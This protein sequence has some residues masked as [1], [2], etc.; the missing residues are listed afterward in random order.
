MKDPGKNIKRLRI[1]LLIPSVTFHNI[2][3]HLA[4][5]LLDWHSILFPYPICCVV[6]KSVCGGRRKTVAVKNLNCCMFLV[7]MRES[8]YSSAPLKM[9]P[10]SGYPVY[11]MSYC[12]AIFK[13]FIVLLSLSLHSPKK[14]FAALMSCHRVCRLLCSCAC[15]VLKTYFFWI[16]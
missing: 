16:L 3:I 14:V 2:M 15:R 11:Q 6:Y 4:N 10:R 9:N 8:V 1:F 12:A 5:F 7:C 13:L